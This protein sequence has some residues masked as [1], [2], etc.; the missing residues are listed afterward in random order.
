MKTCLTIGWLNG[1]ILKGVFLKN[2][3]N[4]KWIASSIICV[5]AKI[6]GTQKTRQL[7][8]FV[9]TSSWKIL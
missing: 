2:D 8:I 7:L 9:N 5:H 4:L 6:D 1:C 3:C